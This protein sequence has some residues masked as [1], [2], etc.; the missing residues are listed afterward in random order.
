MT[1]ATAAASADD[2][3]FYDVGEV[4][5]VGS[6]V[7][8]GGGHR[9]LTESLTVY[10]ASMPKAA[11]ETGAPAA[12]KDEDTSDRVADAGN[13]GSD[14]LR[15]TG[16]ANGSPGANSLQRAVDDESDVVEAGPLPKILSD[17][18]AR[19]YERIFDLQEIGRW[20][21]ADKLIKQLSD[22]ILMGHLLYQ[23]Y[24]HPRRYRARY[25]ELRDWMRKYRDHPGANTVYKLAL[26]RRPKNYRRPPRPKRDPILRIEQPR[27]DRYEGRTGYHQLSSW[28]RRYVRTTQRRIRYYIYRGWPKRALRLLNRKKTR[29]VFDSFSLDESSSVVA[30]GLFHAGRT[31]QA[32]DLAHPAGTRSGEKLP[33]AHWWAGLAAWR[34]GKYHVAAEHFGA[35]TRSEQD[36]AWMQSAGAYWAARSALVTHQPDKVNQYLAMA[37]QFPRTFYGLLAIRSL[38]IEPAYDWSL[39][40]MTQE[41]METLNRIPKARRALALVQVGETSRAELDLKRQSANLSPEMARMLVTL[42]VN[43]NLP[44]L[45][46]R[47][48]RVLRDR[49][50]ETYDAA[51]YPLPEWEPHD[52][53]RID[54][55]LVFAVMRQESRFRIRAKSRAGARGLMQLMPRTAGYMAGRRFRGSRRHQLFDPGLNISLGQK[56]VEHLLEDPHIDGDL[57]YT[58]AAYNGG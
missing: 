7:P 24:M 9:H 54:K 18:D 41:A 40:P 42:S 5:T 8:A 6:A 56:Y 14:T 28:K 37:A 47:V 48:G 16:G 3:E 32:F 25:K 11:P 44:S 50:N 17:A 13:A 38:G 1:G 45:A 20:K 29:R 27:R 23:R 55:A 46:V 33:M 35:M 58:V 39:P 15:T 57:F 49:D 21:Q 2:L 52:G 51:L 30:G 12:A 10:P 43:H 34:L 22:R 31:K 36:E 53:F 19:L 4:P 26:R